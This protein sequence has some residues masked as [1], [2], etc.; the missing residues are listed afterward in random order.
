M[1]GT[2]IEFNADIGEGFGVWATPMQIWRADLERGGSLDPET[3]GS[4]PSI[5]RVMHLV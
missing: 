1:T 4:L 5:E 3:G 2:E